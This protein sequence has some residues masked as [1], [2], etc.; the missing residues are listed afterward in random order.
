MGSMGALI[1][2][3]TNPRSNA[4]SHPKGARALGGAAHITPRRNQGSMITII[5]YPCDH[6]H[7]VHSMSPV[8][9]GSE[10]PS[11]LKDSPHAFAREN[12]QRAR[13]PYIKR[14]LATLKWAS[15]LETTC[16]TS[17]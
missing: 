6:T 11:G 17:S 14:V 16:I 5:T 13:S 15:P 2:A 8:A 12:R 10:G 3:I 9:T 4:A 7:L 1:T